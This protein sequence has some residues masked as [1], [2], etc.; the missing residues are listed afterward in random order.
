MSNDSKPRCE[1]CKFLYLLQHKVDP[2]FNVCECRRYPTPLK[3]KT[4]DWCGEYQPKESV[5][6]P[7]KSKE[8]LF[9]V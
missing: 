7:L 6:E 3:K 4:T 2:T 1:S 5:H 9:N 8:P